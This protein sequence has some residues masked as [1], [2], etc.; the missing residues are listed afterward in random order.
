MSKS[1]FYGFMLTSKV[2]W[3]HELW[4]SRNT[5]LIRRVVGEII[6][7]QF[8]FGSAPEVF[9]YENMT[10]QHSQ[11]TTQMLSQRREIEENRSLRFIRQK[12]KEK[13]ST[14]KKMK[15]SVVV[16]EMFPEGQSIILFILSVFFFSYCG[17][18]YQFFLKTGAGSY[19]DM[20]EV[21]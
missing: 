5:R 18:W 17:Y 9:I 14:V 21:R 8:H 1:N 20:E 3:K 16:D 13:L 6:K 19:M 12:N 7:K 2:N 10:T 15:P 4:R 11:Q